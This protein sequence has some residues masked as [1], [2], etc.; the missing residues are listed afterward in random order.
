MNHIISENAPLI[1]ALRA[2]NNLSG[3][4]MTLLAVDSNHK[5]VGTLTDGD[6]RRGLLAGLALQSPVSDAMHRN[7]RCITSETSPSDI[8]A[9]R[10]AGISLLPVLDEEQRIVEIVDLSCQSTRLPIRAVLM[11][12]GRGERMRPLTDT[13]PKPL[14]P[15]G[16]ATVIDRNVDALRRCGVTDICVTTRYLAEQIEAHFSGSE[17]KCVREDAPLGTIGALSLLPAGDVCGI[18][19]LMN[20]D[21]FTNIDF[22]DFYLQHVESGNDITIATVS[23]TVSI[24]FAVLATDGSKVVGIDE[25]PI[26]TH[27]ANAGIYLISN[28]LLADLKPE[29]L[30]APDFIAQHIERG[31]KVGYFPITGTWLDIGTPADYRQAQ[32]LLRLLPSH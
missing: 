25:K 30:D 22:E 21:L 26:Y 18:T 10:R 24:P 23:H 15:L 4:V 6:V 13:V 7:F 3:D 16:N 17:V 1:D 31:A 19:L 28:S 5:M 9:A 14:L 20:S 12:G 11:A 29:R 2:L 32:E 8:R 27:Y